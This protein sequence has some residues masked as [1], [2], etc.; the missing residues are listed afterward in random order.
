MA[1]PEAIKA[2]ICIIGAGAAGLSVASSAA[3]LGV[4]VVLIERAEM[5]GDCLNRGCVPSKTLIASARAAAAGRHAAALG[6]VFRAPTIDGDVILARLRTVRQEIAPIDSIERYRA[7]GVRVIEE[8]A[9]FTD[10]GTVE[11]GPFRVTARRFVIATGAAPVI[12]GIPGLA[13]TPYLTTDTIFDVPELPR[14]LAVLGGGTVGV[15]LAQ[16]F[17]RLGTAVTL[18]ERDSLLA[19]EDPEAVALV[20]DSLL[21]EGVELL[22]HSEIRRVQP[23]TSGLTLDLETPHGPSML[24]KGHLLVATGRRPAL[25]SL[26][27]DVVGVAT[28]PRG[29]L[30]DDRQ[31]TSNRRILAVGDCTGPLSTHAAAHQASVA[32]RNALFPFRTRARPDTVPSVIYADPEIARV[33]PTE[34]Q[35]RERHAG[36]STLRWPFSEVDRARI[37]DRRSGFVKALI[38]KKGRILGA[39]IVGDGASEAI[40]PWCLAVSEGLKIDAMVGM[41]LPYPTRNEASRRA[42]LQ[43]LTPKLRSPWLARILRWSRMLG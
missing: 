19:E 8:T 40:A 39:T 14:R 25:E 42:A 33:G 1:D 29:I 17:C 5:G 7:L 12:P 34:A 30:V 10:A 20:R 23:L 28:G 15:E 16:A 36:V 35:A 2:D 26:G 41:T 38:D 9:R 43:S 32:L 31:T 18:I 37:D 21:A 24:N 4:P 11:A 22:E 6:V 13:E 3:L 27:L